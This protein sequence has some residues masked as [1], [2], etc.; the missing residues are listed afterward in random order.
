MS[1]TT[2][3]RRYVTI[4]TVGSWAFA[5]LVALLMV[6]VSIPQHM[7]AAE[8]ADTMHKRSVAVAASANSLAQ[9]LFDTGRTVAPVTDPGTGVKYYALGDTTLMAAPKDDKPKPAGVCD[10]NAGERGTASRLLPLTRWNAATLEFHSRIGSDMWD[11]LQNKI[12]RDAVFR[13][14]MGIGNSMWASATTL[15]VQ[16]INFCIL[17][18]AGAIADKSAAKI[19][20][21]I[22]ESPLFVAIIVV[23]LVFFLFQAARTGQNPMKQI[24]S[25]LI[26]AGVFAIMLTGAQ[27]SH[28][29]EN[30]DGSGVAYKPGFGSPGWF[31]VTTTNA[32]Q[33][34]ASAPLAVTTLDLSKDT[35]NYFPGYSKPQ[36]SFDCRYFVSALNKA[37][38]DEYKISHK[39]TMNASIPLMMSDMWVPAGLGAWTTAQFGDGNEFGPK[40]FCFLAD[41]QAGLPAG[42]TDGAKT[43]E[44][45]TQLEPGRMQF[46]AGSGNVWKYAFDK[47]VAGINSIGKP[48]DIQFNGDYNKKFLVKASDRDEVD[49]LMVGLATCNVTSSGYTVAPGWDGWKE[50][51]NWTKNLG[52]HIDKRYPDDEGQMKE[53]CGRLFGENDWK[54]GK[55]FDWSDSAHKVK[56]VIG[57]GKFFETRDF[58]LSLHGA[59]P[60]FAGS[61]TTMVYAASSVALGFV[62]IILAV[63]VILAKATV[64]IMIMVVLV[65]LV[66][67]LLPTTET[68][69]LGKFVKSFFG[70]TLFAAF[71]GLIVSMVALVSKILVDIA[72]T[73]MSA[74]SVLLFLWVGF[75]PVIAIVILHW[76]FK[77]VLGLPSPFTMKSALA[78]G[79]AAGAMG[80][81]AIAGGSRGMEMARN[82]ISS[83]V[84]NRAAGARGASNT[85]ATGTGGKSAE[86]GSGRKNAMPPT[87]RANE[88]AR[89]VAK[90]HAKA[91]AA[92]KTLSSSA[93]GEALKASP[94]GAAAGAV[95]SSAREAGESLRS[96][97]GEFA[98]RAVSGVKAFA[99]DPRGVTGSAISSAGS[100]IGSAG[101][102]IGSGI[103]KSLGGL[104]GA[105]V[106]ALGAAKSGWGDVKS[107]WSAARAGAGSGGRVSKAAAISGAKQRF[108]G[109]KEGELSLPLRSRAALVGQAL[110]N[111]NTSGYITRKFEQSKQNWGE[112]RRQAAAGLSSARQ[113]TGQAIKSA[114]SGTKD[115]GLTMG[116]AAYTDAKRASV[117]AGRSMA[118]ATRRKIATTKSAIRNNVGSRIQMARHRLDM[119]P[120]KALGSAVA[121]GLAGGLALGP[122]G[123]VGGALAAGSA[124][125]ASQAGTSRAHKQIIQQ[126]KEAYAKRSRMSV[127]SS[128]RSVRAPRG[129][130][131]TPPPSGGGSF[132]PPPSGG[133]QW[134]GEGRS[135]AQKAAEDF[136]RRR[137]EQKLANEQ[138]EAQQQATDEHA[139]AQQQATDEQVRAQQAEYERV[140]REHAE[141]VR[142]MQ[143]QD[144]GFEDNPPQPPDYYNDVPPPEAPP[145]DAGGSVNT[146]APH[147]SAQEPSPAQGFEPP[148]HE[149][150]ADRV[151]EEQQREAKRREMEDKD[152]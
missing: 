107:V 62:F 7:V 133:G 63:A 68:G 40:I 28:G 21:A 143:Q 6:A 84:G 42:Y 149:G 59:T 124:F 22:A 70:V 126:R 5:C 151:Y 85:G 50:D 15:T 20:G 127:G 56:V 118:S 51:N 64:I 55:W 130:M 88:Q 97:P 10:A 152:G 1:R 108:G 17:D 19:G 110:K 12:T 80:G 82:A 69:R 141:Q 75:A 53:E 100:A 138:R 43:G 30:F 9:G 58:L 47:N 113:S 147:V 139:R 67:A 150:L 25:K 145:A 132:T 146:G 137:A 148:A 106:G 81:A 52:K 31:A 44:D 39:P 94:L 3:R 73:V 8:P 98:Q 96:A 123:A 11:Q 136:D 144:R 34:V 121:G 142:R 99:S 4:T 102:A 120:G 48:G 36:S 79:G 2:T 72:A 33:A 116:R 16:A 65:L 89:E 125:A 46:A 35:K 66:M 87:M 77:Q 91:Q 103:G 76:L 26:I 111:S 83:Y 131:S 86:V 74:G 104:K 71:A 54:G 117:Q 23:M 105:G 128:G 135:N 95:M 93:T 32:L 41:R 78:Y 57:E 45:S 13:T 92:G 24:V 14:N 38:T 61:S 115:F 134:S 122:V 101:S 114:A 129:G 90:E 119:N 37:Y 60:G 29:G 140:E 109:I 112:A 49:K 18:S 27:G